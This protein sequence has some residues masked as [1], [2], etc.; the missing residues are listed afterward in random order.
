MQPPPRRKGPKMVRKA[1]VSDV[2][3]I[4]SLVNTYAAE[5]RMLPISLSHLYERLRDFFGFVDDTDQLLGCGGLSISWSDLAEVR[6]L[7]VKEDAKRRGIGRALVEA[8]L[9]E[10]RTL[11]LRRVF[12]LTYEVEFFRRMGFREIGKDQL[13]HKVWSVCLNCPKFPN[14]DEIAMVT[15]LD[16]Q[17][18]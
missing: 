2:P 14:C 5:Q 13:P 7:A 10:A 6:S 3:E 18:G 11:G 1:R 4:H 16:D 15:D 12:C 9:E 17:G 8:C